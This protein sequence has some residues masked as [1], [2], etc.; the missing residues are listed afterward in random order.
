MTVTETCR[1]RRSD[2]LLDC[3]TYRRRV[4][5]SL[6]KGSGVAKMTVESLKKDMMNL[7]ELVN[8]IIQ[9]VNTRMG[10]GLHLEKHGP[11]L[12]DVNEQA[13]GLNLV[14]E[15]AFGLILGPQEKEKR[16]KY[17]PCLLPAEKGKMKAQSLSGYSTLG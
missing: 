1:T 10:L 5:G 17:G 8:G 9:I 15:K 7:R 16:M 12:R 13:V 14:N 3:K 4:G 6:F 2:A 11:M